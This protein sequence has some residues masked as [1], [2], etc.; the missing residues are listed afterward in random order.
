MNCFEARNAFRSLWRE[1]LAPD[2][3]RALFDH[4]KGCA[5]CDRAF[6][7]FALSAPVLHSEHPPREQTAIPALRPT[8]RVSQHR[9]QN[10][11]LPVRAA[12]A[13]TVMFTLAAGLAA[14]LSAVAPRES[15]DQALTGPEPAAVEVVDTQSLDLSNDLVR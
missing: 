10:D 7:T 13:A 14:Y 1:E 15:L 3:R 2:A 12:L 9:G 8:P 11:S 4:L 6:R 5:P